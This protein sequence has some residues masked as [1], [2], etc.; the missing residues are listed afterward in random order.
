[1]SMAKEIVARWESL[2]RVRQRV[3]I[4][5]TLVAVY[6]LGV[7]GLVVPAVILYLAVNIG[8]DALT[9]DWFINVRNRYMKELVDVDAEKLNREIPVSFNS[10][11]AVKFAILAQSKVGILK[12]SVANRLV[13]ETTLLHIFEDFNVRHNIR[14]ELLGEALV[15][16]FIRPDEYKRALAIIE[17]MGED[18]SFI[19]H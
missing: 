7:A 17:M 9:L 12:P 19:S 18:D 16:C 4:L 10:R 3:T 6:Y 11:T 8:I 15:A 14:M 1:M 13:Y 2:S 5:L